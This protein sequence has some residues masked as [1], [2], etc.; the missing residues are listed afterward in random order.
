M[1]EIYDWYKNANWVHYWEIDQFIGVHSFV[2][3]KPRQ[4]CSC[5]KSRQLDAIYQGYT[6]WFE[7]DPGWRDAEA[8]P[9]ELA[10]WGCPYKY[11]E[12]DLFAEQGKKTLICG[13]YATSEFHQHYKT[14]P[15]ADGCHDIY[16]SQDLI[17]LDS[18]VAW[19]NQ[20][21]VLVIDEDGTC[22]DQ[23]NHKLN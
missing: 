20:S 2:P 14:S 16:F 10:T 7:A 3:V 22:Y 13:H 23:Y 21:N 5:V 19:S 12:A 11:L 9:W 1:S 8:W 15:Y 4:A 17:A 18:S 6:D